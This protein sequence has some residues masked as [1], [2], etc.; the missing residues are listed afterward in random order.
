[1]VICLVDPL[2]P[3]RTPRGEALRRPPFRHKRR[4]SFVRASLQALQGKEARR[5]LCVVASNTASEV[6][7]S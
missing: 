2:P 4:A 3:P 6:V 1:M 5:P 7:T